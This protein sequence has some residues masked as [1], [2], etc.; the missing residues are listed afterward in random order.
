MIARVPDAG[1]AD[2]DAAVAAARACFETDAWQATT[3]AQRAVWLR[4]IAGELRAASERLALIESAQNGKPF[5]E[6]LEDVEASAYT[7]DYYGKLADELDARQMTPVDVPDARFKAY[8]RFEP[9]GVAAHITPFNYPLLM[10]C[11][12]H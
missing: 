2:V 6:A 1:A 3:G 4:A 5:Q 7:F 11:I 12:C 10:V 8:L 9:G